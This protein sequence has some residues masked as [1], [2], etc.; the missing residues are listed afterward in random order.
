MVIH[1]GNNHDVRCLTSLNSQPLNQR[2]HIP[3]RGC[4]SGIYTSIR[5]T[6]WQKSLLSK[7]IH[8]R[9]DPFF[10]GSKRSG[11]QQTTEKVTFINECKNRLWLTT[12]LRCE[13]NVLY[14][15]FLSRKRPCSDIIL[16]NKNVNV[17][18]RKYSTLCLIFFNISTAGTTLQIVQT[19][20]IENQLCQKYAFRNSIDLLTFHCNFRPHSKADSP[21]I[22]ESHC[23]KTCLRSSP[24]LK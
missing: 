18:N 11:V 1:L 21:S 15:Q 5:Y 22:F 17:C 2:R 12:I 13:R 8:L 20:C 19:L 4:R 3:R 7:F 24:P 16:A 9:V 6:V 14:T 23:A 10:D